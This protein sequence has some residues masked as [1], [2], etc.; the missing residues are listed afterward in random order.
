MNTTEP[1][2]KCIV[3]IIQKHDFALMKLTMNEINNL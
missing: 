2:E 3:R 1:N